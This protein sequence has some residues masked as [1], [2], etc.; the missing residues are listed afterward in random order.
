MARLGSS[1]RALRARFLSPLPG[2][3]GKP[4]AVGLLR[5]AQVC[6]G[7]LAQPQR[8]RPMPRGEKLLRFLAELILKKICGTVRIRFDAG[9]VTH[10]EDETHAK[11]G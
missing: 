4:R 6:H 8:R 2:L 7:W 11:W 1:S 10:V 5:L 9:K 3:T